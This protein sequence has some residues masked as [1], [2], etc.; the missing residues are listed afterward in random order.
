[1]WNLRGTSII[2]PQMCES[3]GC[4][5]RDAVVAREQR[6]ARTEHAH[7]HR[8]ESRRAGEEGPFAQVPRGQQT[9]LAPAR[10]TYCSIGDSRCNGTIRPATH[11]ANT[12]NITSPM[13]RNIREQQQRLHPSNYFAT[14]KQ[15]HDNAE[16]QA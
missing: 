6:P 7:A 16:K 13:Y 3:Y 4:G 8:S 11:K 9:S 5:Y 15:S 12:L 14:T 10:R 1:M 2:W